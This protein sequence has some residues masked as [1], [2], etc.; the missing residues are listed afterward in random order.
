MKGVARADGEQAAGYEAMVLAFSRLSQAVMADQHP[1][2]VLPAVAETGA[3]L[4]QTDAGAAFIYEQETDSLEL[5][6]TYNFEPHSK[7]KSAPLPAEAVVRDCINIGCAVVV[8]NTTND[9]RRG[10]EA[11]SKNGLLSVLCVPLKAAGH[12]VGVLAAMSS[13]LRAFSPSDI[14]VLDAVADQASLAVLRSKITKDS[15]EASH[16]TN[17]ELINLANRKIQELSIVNRV[18]EAVTSTLDL[19]K[20]LDH[21]LDECLSAMN[22][23]V[24]SIMLLD[25]KKERLSIRAARG[26]DRKIVDSASVEIGEGIA[27]WVAEQGQ[28]VLVH[29]AQNDS[30]FKLQAPRNDI[31]S[32]MSVPLKARNSVIGVLNISTTEQ[33]RRFGPRDVEFLSIIANH[34]AMAIDNARLFDRLERRSNELALLLKISEAI[35]SSLALNDV[36]AALSQSFEA[37]TQVDAVAVL[38]YDSESQRFRCLEGVGMT[39]HTRNT[40]YLELAKTAGERVLKT[41]SLMSAKIMPDTA[42]WNEIAFTEGFKAF[43]AVPL[44]ASG[45]FVGATVLF[46]RDENSFDSVEM[47]TFEILGE[48]A[49]VAVRNSMVFQHQYDIARTFTKD[50]TPKVPESVRG[51]EI[52]HKFLP[53]KDIGGDY[54]DFIEA[55]QEGMGIVIADVAGNS[56]PAAMY[57][58]MGRHVLRAYAREGYAP[59]DV[60]GRLNR[61]VCEESHPELFISLFYGV[62][63]AKNKIFRYACAGHEPP[64]LFRNNGAVERLCAPGV[65]I[66]ITPESSYEEKIS[67]LESGDILLFF[68]DGLIESQESRGRP[69]I[70]D[71]EEVVKT[72]FLKPAQEIADNLLERL[73]ETAGSRAADDVALVLVRI[74]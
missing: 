56:V 67:Q 16:K 19:T 59:A 23:N 12:C 49:G 70:K 22:A 26:L 45:R 68:T 31:S 54:Y 15:S 52:G 50:L 20:V 41:G 44:I 6:A 8:T 51:I 42:Y 33:G 35:T 38:I 9:R 71:I 13:T 28:P 63:N 5:A 1:K 25:E 21:A 57:T 72:G 18:S 3:I 17:I 34:V 39:K 24:G 64:I 2:D 27:G 36:L 60:L 37:M 73:E 14:A 74:K 4:L 11:L 53:A 30:R 47:R 58:S 69:N 65:L 43:L 55:G 7:S 62:L 29:D 10:M 61:I 32:A 46:S 48:L 40:A 66:G